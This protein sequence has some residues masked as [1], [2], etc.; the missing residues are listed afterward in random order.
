MTCGGRNKGVF[1]PQKARPG[2]CAGV[3]SA[4]SKRCEWACHGRPGRPLMSYRGVHVRVSGDIIVD[5]ELGAWGLGLLT[6]ERTGL[7]YLI[8]RARWTTS[9]TFMKTDQQF[10]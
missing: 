9:L 2:K 7:H 5:R 4:S 10:N 3:L 1:V 6:E 8:H